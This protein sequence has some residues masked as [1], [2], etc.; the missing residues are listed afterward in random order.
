MN[1]DS[2]PPEPDPN[3]DAG[4]PERPLETAR[5][6]PRPARRSGEARR[7]G[8]GEPSPEL[9]ED[10]RSG[11][12]PHHGY[13]YG[14]GYGDLLRPSRFAETSQLLSNL[15]RYQLTFRKHWWVLA[16]TLCAALGP[17]SYYTY[18]VPPSH[19]STAK[20]WF[21]GKLNLREG[22]LYAEELTTFVGT[23]VELLKSST[24]YDRALA[25]LL[26][27]HPDWAETLGLT[28]GATGPFT[29]E[30]REFPKTSIIELKA[31]GK[32]PVPTRQ[33][34]DAIM[35]E[36]QNF[37]RDVRLQ[38]SGTTLASIAEQVKQLEQ[39]LRQQQERL[40]SFTASNNVVLLQEQG[41]SAGAYVGRLNR[42]LAGLRT[43]YGLLQLLSPEQLTQA[44]TKTKGMGAD[45]PAAGDDSAR[46]LLLS[47]SGP[48]A[49]FLKASQQ[50]EL[51]KLQR[52]ELSE[53][54]RPI[55][56]KITKLDEEIARQEQVVE[57]FK[58]QSLGQMENRRQALELQILGL[59]EAARQWEG[60][61]VDASRK[62]AEYERIR[63]DVQRTQGLYERLLG[64]IQSLDVS[65]TLDQ[66]SMRVMEAASKAKPVRKAVKHLAL[67]TASGL[68][69]GLG[70]LYLLNLFD[71]RF[72]SIGELRNHLAEMVVGQVPEV[73][74]SK[75][76][77][78][79]ELIR[80]DDERHVFAESF[81]NIR[82]WILFS[83]KDEERPKMILVTSSVP[84]EGKTTMVA[85]LG[86]TLALAGAKVL[87]VD[88]DLRRAGLYKT[89]GRSNEPGMAGILSQQTRY[90]DAIVPTK[91]PN[92]FLLP[93][94]SP[95]LNP[96]ELFLAPSCDIF[97]SKI[98]GQYDYILF[99]SAPVLATDDSTSLAPKLDGVLFVVRADFTSARMA[100]ESLAMLHE[101]NAN[102]LGLV[103]NRASPSRGDGYYY[104]Y[105]YS[106]YYYY[107]GKRKKHRPAETSC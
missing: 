16:L 78:T 90:A 102:L 62:M 44:A 88:A 1:E 68:F 100:R 6:V 73:P 52:Q 85:N 94:G 10:L 47:L 96:G 57:V 65:R 70:L 106:D 30:V 64:V 95:E 60:K 66:E 49:D 84:Q 5:P 61:A 12:P 2:R 55:H 103:F 86:V 105:R 15:R 3:P 48:Q 28:N 19:Q 104:Y 98:R 22:Q 23:Q 32:H 72:T 67:G 53:V 13:G 91:V 58:R 93:A 51:L 77:A 9:A 89:F 87:L 46:E 43:E 24:I 37:R 101:R 69:L 74:I 18:T 79:L 7:G 45:E 54:L 35:E 75:E 11:E 80:E 8:D 27:N 83:Y 71:D 25:N 82:S 41:S 42:Q 107:G 14:Y 92:L 21:S 33:F 4:Q 76:H 38:S 39:D 40:H 31:V 29:L 20:M 59:E 63:Q 36:Y 26:N 81:R 34:L 50:I 97:L 56:P 17:V 99:D